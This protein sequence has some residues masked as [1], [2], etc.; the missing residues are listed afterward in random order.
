MVLKTHH[1]WIIIIIF[2]CYF[3]CCGGIYMVETLYSSVFVY[4]S[5]QFAFSDITLVT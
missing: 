3:L 2:F 1:W 4:I 5:S